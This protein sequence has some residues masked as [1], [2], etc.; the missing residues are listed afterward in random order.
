LS[1]AAQQIAQLVSV[2]GHE[3]SPATLI[4]VATELGIAPVIDDVIRAGVIMETGFGQAIVPKHALTG[5]A[6]QETVDPVVKRRIHRLLGQVTEG[7]RS[8]RKTME[9][10]GS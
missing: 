9:G 2:A 10:A 6:I 4:E 1:E 7:L 3:L 8:V 5:T